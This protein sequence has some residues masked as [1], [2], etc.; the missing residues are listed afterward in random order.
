MKILHS[1]RT[2]M[3]LTMLSAGCLAWPA[4][5]YAGQPLPHESACADLS[6]AA[7]GL[8]NAFCNAQHCDV[9]QHPSCKILRR[10]FERLTGSSTFPCEVALTPTATPTQTQVPPTATATVELTPT[11]TAPPPT[12]TATATGVPTGT[13]TGVIG[14]M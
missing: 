13:A 2:W 9:E 5:T 12:E 7:F 1:S 14:G 4:R 6:G 11:A 3:V 10:N 8:C